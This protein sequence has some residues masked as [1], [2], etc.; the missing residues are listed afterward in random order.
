MPHHKT[1]A[2]LIFLACSVFLVA[3]AT[4]PPVIGTDDG[5]RA[6]GKFSYSSEE[7]RESGNFDWR[8]NGQ[9]YRIRLYGPLGLG[10]VQIN[11]NDR[12]VSLKSSKEEYSARHPETLFY[13]TTGMHLP[14]TDIPGW[15]RGQPSAF[16]TEHTELDANGRI[17]RAFVQGWHLEYKNYSDDN[18]LPKEVVAMQDDKTLRLIVLNWEE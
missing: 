8:Q 14:L 17:M 4:Q 10:A 1:T 12:Q 3:C 16:H 9:E 6:R 2:L 13:E 15:L 5:W 18:P 7:T 11:G